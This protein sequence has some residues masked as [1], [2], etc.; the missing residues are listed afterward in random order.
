M[1]GITR[2]EVAKL[3][4]KSVA[5][6]RRMEGSELHPTVDTKGVNRFAPDD[7]AR[8]AAQ[9]Q[10]SSRTTTRSSRTE[11]FDDELKL[12][13]ENDEYWARR[14]E[15]R[16]REFAEWESGEGERRRA[17][18]Q[19]Q[20]DRQAKAIEES[21]RTREETARRASAE[22]ASRD[23]RGLRTQAAELL[24]GID[25][26]SERQLRRAARDGELLDSLDRLLDD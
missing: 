16:E 11:W 24:G 18:E 3:L 6:V 17:A 12:R 25:G 22:R 5:T 9:K 10:K 15:Q 1:A 20:R 23:S 2:G 7:V 26:M 14:K 21:E 8:V 4:G 19:W 13:K